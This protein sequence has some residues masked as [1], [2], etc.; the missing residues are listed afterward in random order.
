MESFDTAARKYL[1]AR[2]ES[3]SSVAAVSRT[4]SAATCAMDVFRAPIELNLLGRDTALQWLHFI[5]FYEKNVGPARKTP[6]LLGDA[7]DL[8][9]TKYDLAIEE[10][11]TSC[12]LDLDGSD[13]E[14]EQ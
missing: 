2:C 10:E 11:F 7:M 8:I 1:S 3:S 6:L 13:E 14:V 9:S 12:W 4:I 5:Q